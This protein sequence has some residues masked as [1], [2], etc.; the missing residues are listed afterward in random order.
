MRFL[1]DPNAQVANIL[2]GSVDAVVSGASGSG[3]N[4]DQAAEVKRRWEGTGN[5]VLT[6]ET[7]QS[8]HANP[9]YQSEYARPREAISNVLVRRALLHAIDRSSLAETMTAGL[10]PAADSYIHPGDP[11]FAEM[12]PYIAKF[13]YDPVRAQ[14]LLVEAGWNRAPDGV[15]TRA[16]DGQRLELDF[17][18]R[19]GA[20]EKVASIIADDWNRVGIPTAPYIIPIARV[21]DREYQATRPGFLCCLRVPFEMMEN[22]N[23]LGAKSIPTAA[24]NWT[25]LNFGGYMNPRVEA[26]VDRLNLTIDPRERLPLAQQLVQEYTSDVALLPLWWEIFPMLMLQGIKGPRTNFLLPTANIFEWD[27]V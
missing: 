6:S 19:G 12:Q 20:N 25:G 21:T 9:Q 2:S 16:S 26:L 14:Q 15:F 1:I 5:Q 7:G 22:G 4:L 23:Q 13:P 27:R 18:N 10:S 3:I 11:R 24:T 17:W 8:Q